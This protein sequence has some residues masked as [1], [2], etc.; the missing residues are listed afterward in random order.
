MKTLKLKDGLYFAG[1]LDSNLR[2]FDIVMYTEFG[3]T[4]NSYIL[5]GSEK[6][7]LIE[8]AK[9][10]FFDDYLN[11]IN[12]IDDVKNID[13]IIVNHTEPDHAGSV[14]KLVQINPEITVVGTP[15]ALTYLKNIVNAPFKSQ[16]VKDGDSL[17]LGGKTLRFMTVPN[18]HWPD[19]MYTY[20]EEDKVL[21]TCDSFGSHYSFSEILRSKVTDTDGYMRA[22]KYYFD[23]II[24][25]FKEK[26]MT[27]ALNKIS[28]LDID[29][30]CT[31]HGPVLDSNI[32]EL[33]DIYKSWCAVPKND[34]KKVV[35]AF[36]SAYGYTKELAQNI[37]KGIKLQADIDVKLF[38]MQDTSLDTVMTEITASDGILL[39]S[40]TILSDALKPIWD[41]TSSMFPITHGGK[42]A[43]AFGSYGWSGEAVPNITERLKQLKMKTVDGFR[44]K[45]KPNEDELNQAIEFGK[46][47]AEKL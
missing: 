36:V 41:I 46:E 24:G 23:N 38:D 26:F 29:M 43:G 6:T 13:Y 11:S 1:I 12:E 2:V 31:G 8:T 15:T 22:T 35:I 37:E 33:I 42:V 20:S 44:V 14:E 27:R 16:A 30:I 18:L 9:A 19:T 3:T 45:F 5:K 7:A 47:F 25:P 32:D 39:G 34:K 17:S 10:K 40:P 4:Y 21:F 28:T